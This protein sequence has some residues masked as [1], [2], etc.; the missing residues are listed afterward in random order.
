[1]MRILKY[2]LIAAGG[3]LLILILVGATAFFILNSRNRARPEALSALQ[4]DEVVQISTPAAT[5]WLVFTPSDQQSDT[6]FIIYPGGFV[7]ARAYAPVAREI[8]E[9]GFT[10]VLDPMPL[11][12]AVL[13]YGSADRIISAFPEI[14]SWAIGGHSLGGAMAAQFAAGNPMA[15]DG[16]ALW[17]SYPAENID[18]SQVPLEVVSIFGDSDG[19]ASLDTITQSA[20]QLPPNAVFVAIPGGNH[21]QFGWYG[22]GLQRGDN[23]AGISREEQQAIIINSTVQMLESIRQ[24]D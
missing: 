13:D 16:L 18:L 6:G 3:L 8:A 19:V 12:L 2:G 5:D 21:T 24:T 17:G 11:N 22:E 23:P 20:A 10:V 4:S 15:V 14:N 7:D 1:M 9:A